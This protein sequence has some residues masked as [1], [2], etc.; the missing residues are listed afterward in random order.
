MFVMTWDRGFYQ[1]IHRSANEHLPQERK[2]V[3]ASRLC[4][5][6]LA[7]ASS[8]CKHSFALLSTYKDF[9]PKVV[10]TASAVSSSKADI[11]NTHIY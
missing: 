3:F 11:A 1:Y 2:R 6:N 7:R 8:W 10:I 4:R 5:D 9:C